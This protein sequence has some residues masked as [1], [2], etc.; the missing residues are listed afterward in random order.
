VNAIGRYYSAEANKWKRMSSREAQALSSAGIEIWVVYQNAHNDDQS[1][2]ARK[3]R[4][5]A[6][7]ALEYAQNVIGQP[8][9]TAIYFAADY[10]AS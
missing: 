5:E 8:Q 7:E 10:D 2:S 9:G 3:G 4:Q 6:Q 1:F